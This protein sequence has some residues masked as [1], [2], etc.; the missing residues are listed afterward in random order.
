[1]W[2]LVGHL[3]HARELGCSCSSIAPLWHRKQ[4]ACQ[5]R[6]TH[7]RTRQSSLRLQAPRAGPRSRG[8]PH[9]KHEVS[10]ATRVEAA[11]FCLSPKHVESSVDYSR[12]QSW[13]GLSTHIAVF[14]ATRIFRVFSSFPMGKHRTRNH[15]SGPGGLTTLWYS[16]YF[17]KA[18]TMSTK[19]KNIRFRET[20]FNSLK[21]RVGL[22]FLRP[23][24][25]GFLF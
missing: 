17:N 7:R 16:H 10:Q 14:I 6:L 12:A 13:A 18:C 21:L 9:P 23:C 11:V 24:I 5:S 25:D 4:L 2:W 20:Q 22:F 1:M 19:Q 15:R 8:S 3:Y